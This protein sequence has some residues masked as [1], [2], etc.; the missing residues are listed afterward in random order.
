[1]THQ[2]NLQYISG[3]QRIGIRLG[4]A[5]VSRLLERLNNPQRAYRTILVGG[6]NGKGS[7]C[8]M[9]ASMLFH[10]GYRVG[11]YTSPHLIDLGERI[12]VDGRMIQVDEL[13][14]CIEAVRREVREDVTYF[15]FV[16]AL[17]FLHF[18]RCN[19]D[20]AVVEVGMGGRL[21]ATN[22]VR[23]DVSVISNISLEHREYLGRR[24]SDIAWEKGGIIKD[25][26]LCITAARQGKVLDILEGICRD[27]GARL[28]RV[29]RD[30]KVRRNEDGT[31]S[32]RG[33]EKTYS[34]LTCPLAGRHQLENAGV[35]LGTMEAMAACG[36]SVDDH[37]LAMGLKK[38]QWP[39][40]LEVLGRSPVLLVDGAHNPAGAAALCRALKEEFTYD[41][42]ILVFGVLGDKDSRSMLKQLAPLADVLILTK[43]ATDRAKPPEELLSVAVRYHDRIELTQTTG[44]ALKLALTK[45]GAQDLICCTGS[46][47]LVGEIRQAVASGLYCLN[48]GV[49]D[50]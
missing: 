35:A 43:P 8:A 22:V 7:I 34:H 41:R 36:L 28:W 30:I 27:R 42:L 11:L 38:A 37:A 39:G 4:L 40:R 20:V 13:D 44:E 15:E 31:F 48:E 49:I 12:R 9:T 47:Y 10:N 5:P 1:M 6:T 46:L 18:F 23:P 26:G 25:R 14:A 29:G 50:A 19:V 16:T 33:V 21:D 45:A 24:L 3:L 32:Y 2:D 17:A